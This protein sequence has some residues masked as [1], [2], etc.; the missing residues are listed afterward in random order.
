MPRQRALQGCGAR[1]DRRQKVRMGHR[2]Q[3]RAAHG[4]HQRIAAVGAPLVAALEAVRPQTGQQRRQ[5]HAATQTLGQRHHVGRD[6]ALFE[7]EQRAGAA[8]AGLHFVEDQ[9]QV[10]AVA[11]R[12]QVAQECRRRGDHAGLAL[13]RL[14]HHR[15]RVRSDQRLDRADVAQPR[16]RKAGYLGL[17]QPVPAGLARGA[18]R[19][20]RTAVERLREGDDLV[21][22]TAMPLTPAPRQLDRTLVGLGAAG[23]Q[24]HPRQA[25]QVRQPRGQRDRLVVEH[26]RA[27]VDQPLRLPRQRLHDLRRAMA[28]HVDRP[29]L[30]E[31]EVTFASVIDQPAASARDEHLRRPGGDVHQGIG[32]KAVD[33]HRTSFAG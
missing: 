20:Q 9:Q 28:E 8:D 1:V 27:G 25:R 33:L 29:A 7:G 13:H 16:L 17:E 11:Q 23:G 12:A 19:G 14:Q 3:H 26:A 10:V 22:A 21:R 5:R 15:H 32:L 4:G 30:D 31:I 6:T 24:E 2:I 18:H